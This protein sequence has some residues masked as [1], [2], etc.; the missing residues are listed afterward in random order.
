MCAPRA[1]ARSAAPRKRHPRLGR[2]RI[3]LGPVGGVAVG[4]QVVARQR[5]GQLVGLERLEVARRGEVADLPVALRQRVVGDLADE[6]LDERVLAALWRARVDLLDE[7]LA[8]DERPQP[9]LDRCDVLARHRRDRRP[10]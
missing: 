2:Q 5:A 6:R 9:R 10:A 1:A 7:Q 3:G 8:P 4:R